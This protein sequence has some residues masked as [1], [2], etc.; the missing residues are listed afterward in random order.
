MKLVI[1]MLKRIYTFLL[2]LV[3]VL[4]LSACS[5][6]DLS[7]VPPP[8]ETASLPVSTQE[9]SSPVQ[10]TPPSG[11]EQTPSQTPEPQPTESAA[12]AVVED[13]RYNSKEE[14]ALYIHLYG[15][16][17]GNYLTKREA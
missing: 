16:L 13:G 6:P 11:P 4:A 8:A 3:W 2:T 17:P 7:A 14:V 9:P 12:P 1:D 15:C 5:G 10:T